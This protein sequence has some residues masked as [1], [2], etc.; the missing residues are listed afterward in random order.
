MY[1]F[2]FKYTKAYKVQNF[3]LLLIEYSM[4][5]FCNLDYPTLIFPHGSLYCLSI[6]SDPGIFHVLC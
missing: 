5:A 6:F 4:Q 3:S 1:T 2:I